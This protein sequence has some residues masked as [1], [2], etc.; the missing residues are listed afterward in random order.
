MP[1]LTL[2]L[3]PDTPAV[4]LVLAITDAAGTPLDPSAAY[5]SYEAAFTRGATTRPVGTDATTLLATGTATDTAV[6]FAFDADQTALLARARPD[7]LH[8]ASRDATG[9]LGPVA[10]YDVRLVALAA[11]ADAAV[12]EVDFVWRLDP[13]GTVASTIAVGPAG[14]DGVDGQDGAGGGSLAALGVGWEDHVDS[15]YTSAS[16]LVLSAGVKVT[17]PNDG[18]GPFS[19]TAYSPA[20]RAL[21]DPVANAIVGSTGDI[22]GFNLDFKARPTSAGT[23]TLETSV[24]IGAPVGEIYT[25]LFTFPKGNGVERPILSTTIAYTL[26]T[27]EANG[28]VPKVVANGPCEIY[29]IRLVVTRLFKAS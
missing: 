7:R 18:A 27:W 24:D 6:T 23:T 8:L 25:R 22:I 17:L 13:Q 1:T 26:G 29:D 16:P 3:T 5:Q 11:D 12:Q 14:A 9:R 20:D 10:S 15:V 4:R 21:Y 2:S 28:G 19:R